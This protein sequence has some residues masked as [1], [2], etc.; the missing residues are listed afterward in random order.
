[1]V[2]VTSVDRSEWKR[3]ATV[4][5]SC[6]E[7]SFSL[8]IPIPFLFLFILMSFNGNWDGLVVMIMCG[9]NEEEVALLMM[10]MV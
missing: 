7:I 3:A 5:V 10:V 4:A 6:G 2:V 8:S 1:V 9:L